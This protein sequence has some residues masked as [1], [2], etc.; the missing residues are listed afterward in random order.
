MTLRS[1]LPW[2][3][4]DLTRL[5]HAIKTI[6]MYL[7]SAYINGLQIYKS[8]VDRMNDLFVITVVRY[9]LHDGDVSGI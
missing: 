1:I 4:S 5:I 6:Y 7:Y 8:T 9:A 3:D 2:A